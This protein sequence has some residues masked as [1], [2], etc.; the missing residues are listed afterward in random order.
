MTICK[1]FFLPF[2]YLCVILNYTL[3]IMTKKRL[4]ISV[5][6]WATMISPMVAAPLTDGDE[7]NGIHVVTSAK[8]KAGKT[9]TYDFLFSSEPTISYVNEYEVS[10]LV[11]RD[12]SLSAKDVKQLYGV[13]AI[14]LH[15]DDV[16]SIA[17]VHLNGTGI[18]DIVNGSLRVSVLSDGQLVISGLQGG[19]SVSVYALDG[20][21]IS[22][23]K[24]SANGD[25]SVS[26]QGV[27][28]GSVCIVKCGGG[29]FKVRTK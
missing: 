5:A 14:L 17:F 23:V 11:K 7:I 6:L 18:N 8:D 22:A 3:L 21:L 28:A 10:T 4:L 16:K 29:A 25:A 19:A 26:L 13:E 20:Q 2:A 27:A 24:A 15:Q 1:S 12:L 9:L